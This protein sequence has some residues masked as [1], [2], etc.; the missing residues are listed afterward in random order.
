MIDTRNKQT[1]SR[2]MRNLKIETADEELKRT[3][4]HAISIESWSGSIRVR[5][6]RRWLLLELY[7]R[8]QKGRANM[9]SRLRIVA[10][11]V[12]LLIFT[13][14]CS[15]TMLQPQHPTASAAVAN[16]I[17][18][19][20]GAE[21][22]GAYAS[23]GRGGQVLYVTTLDPDPDGTQPGSLNW[24]LR[25][26]GSRYILFKVSGVI[27]ATANIV[28]GNVTIAGQTSPGGIIVRGLLC[29]GH[30]DQN[31]C[32]NLIV[33]HLRS[34]P[35][36]QID[37]GGLAQ[38]DAL[39]LDGIQNFIIDHS[40]FANA[41]DEATQISW[42]MS[43]TI[44]NSI[45][46]ETVGDHWQYGGMLL[47][48]SIDHHP[49][50]YLSIHHNLFYRLGGRLPEITCEASA[51]PIDPPD[52][53]DCAAHPLHLELS[54]NLLWDPGINIWYTRDVD[55][56]PALGSYV[57]NLNWVNNYL[58]ARN[59]FGNGFILHEVLDVITNSLYFSGNQMSL[60]PAYADYEL[61]YCCNDFSTSGNNPNTD[62]GIATRRTTR[63]AFPSISYTS[64]DRVISYTI[65]H[66]GAFPR[67]PMDR[68]YIASIAAGQLTFSVP[69]SEPITNDAFALDFDPDNP[70]PPPLDT[71]GDGM[72]DAW[73]T[74]YG[75]NPNVQDHNGPELSVPF[76]GIAGYTNLECYLNWLADQLVSDGTPTFSRVYLPLVMRTVSSAASPDTARDLLR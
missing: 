58:A 10:V 70:P 44:Q 66:V 57:L 65:D 73:E 20:P 52:A 51:Y 13:L 56:N 26:N 72:P 6:G 7:N 62:L 50:D 33:R 49:Q 11:V 76:T 17:P 12:C 18:A 74:E 31:N 22:F 61:A 35:A 45:L 34:R 25:Q 59:D 46:G 40:S 67:D 41:V 71:D 9:N 48:Y 32:D 2:L 29:D 47:N 42:A 28:H 69:Y 19:F 15:L 63:H 3:L 68:R 24:A 55:N 4:V 38:D 8:H 37:G 39:R 14:A 43:G 53:S 23:G 60:Y 1:L 36:W 64:T 5:T 27:S 30:Y 54:N 75:L 16:S 21:G